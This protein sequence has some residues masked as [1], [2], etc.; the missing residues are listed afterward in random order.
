MTDLSPIILF[1][2]NRPN[3][4]TKTLE[5]LARNTLAI[6]SDLYIFSDG[7]KNLVEAQKINEVRLICERIQGFAS[8]NISKS[9]GNK[10]LA[11]SVIQG[12][13]HVLKKHNSCIVL[14]DDI[15][16]SID[17]L[18]FMNE[19]L[20]AYKYQSEI[21]SIS[22]YNYPNQMEKIVS[23]DVFLA[24]RSSSWGW[25]TWA[26]RWKDV[27]WSVSDYEDF[28]GNQDE[29]SKFKRGGNDLVNMLSM[30][31][32]GKIDSWSIRFDY[33]HFKKMDTVYT[34]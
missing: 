5:A 26:D 20:N 27:D 29:I 24:C 18:E 12:V 4:L 30:Q 32:K 33:F 19:A 14:E 9:I 7:P 16:T 1:V 13:T 17:F 2:Y 23:G 10:G 25:A 28:I 6:N 34:Q 8:V 15:L 3:H 22:G 31:M 11:E 21:I